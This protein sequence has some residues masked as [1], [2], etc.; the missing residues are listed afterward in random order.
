M[1][2]AMIT[3]LL[4]MLGQA[5]TEAPT[6]IADLKKLIAAVEGQPPAAPEPPLQPVVDAEMADQA[7]KLQA[8]LPKQ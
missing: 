6:I 7:A 2:A 1:S 8:A 3:L 5:I 4:Q